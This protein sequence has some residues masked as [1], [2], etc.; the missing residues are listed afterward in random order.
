MSGVSVMKEHGGYAGL[1]YM[2]QT[3]H[4]LYFPFVCPEE[5]RERSIVGSMESVRGRESVTSRTTHD[6]FC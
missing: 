6:V 3:L 1:S 2:N 4:S 5:K